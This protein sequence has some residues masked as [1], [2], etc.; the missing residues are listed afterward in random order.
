MAARNHGKPWTKPEIAE[1]RKSYRKVLHRELA[2]KLD[3][4]LNS[5]ESKATELGL[6]QKKK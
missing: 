3:R 4:T 2:T 1:L 6:T 5:V